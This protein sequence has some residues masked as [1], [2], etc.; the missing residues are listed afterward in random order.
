MTEDPFEN[1]LDLVEAAVVLKINRQSLARL[2]RQG[3]VPAM[4]FAGRYLIERDKLE[5]FRADYHP[6]RGP[7]PVRRLF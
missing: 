6:R 1:Y 4:L 7:K 2:I 3:K 5:V